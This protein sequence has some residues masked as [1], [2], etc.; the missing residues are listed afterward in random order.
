M[1]NMPRRQ[2]NPM[3]DGKNGDLRVDFD[4]R[5][6]LTFLGSK[7]TTDAGLLAYRELDEVRRD[8]GWES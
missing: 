2:G 7:V 8:R 4:R 3:G 6:K 5:V 1:L